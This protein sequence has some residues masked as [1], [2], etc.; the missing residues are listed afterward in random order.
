[1]KNGPERRKTKR[2]KMRRDVLIAPENSDNFHNARLTN[3]SS[4]GA[5]L[6]STHPFQV[7]SMIYIITENQPIDDFNNKFAEAHYANVIWCRKSKSQYRI[8]AKIAEANQLETVIS[9]D[10]PNVHEQ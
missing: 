6:Q 10:I 1:M 5:C 8:G 3:Y 4:K 7:S 9:N 2:V